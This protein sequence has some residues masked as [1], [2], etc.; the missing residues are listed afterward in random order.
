M[1]IICLILL[2]FVTPIFNSMQKNSFPRTAISNNLIKAEI[3][4]PDQADGYYQGTRFDWSGVIESLKYSGHEYFGKWFD[5]YDPKIHDAIMGPV[6]DFLPVDY[7]SA[8]PGEKFLKIGIGVINKPD[9][10]PWT[11][12][13]T[14]PVSDYGTWK[15]KAKADQVQF[16]HNLK[17][18]KY[19]Y[20]Y[21]KNVRILKDKPVM[22]L[23]HSFK[24]KG[25]STIETL[26]YNHNFFV[27]DNKMVGP[28]YSAEFPFKISGV[29]RDGPALVNI[30]DNRFTLLRNIAKGETIFS[31]GLQGSGPIDKLY[32]IKVENK[33]TGAG[34]RITCDKPLEKLVF[35][36]NPFTFCPEP[37]I[38]LKAEPGETFEW[39]I[40]YEFY[41][42][43]KD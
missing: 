6:D 7:E 25:K 11:F 41:S 34:V 42:L 24:N 18:K 27:I 9:S 17:D 38:R 4:L 39:T 28:G 29:F 3:L 37:Y 10:E 23:T 5:K 40:T 2:F 13:R 32:E 43:S 36:A 22:V 16:I 31:T 20:E 8:K 26:V 1:K 12:A 14:Y 30:T 21:E 15:V 35:W 19:V 33:E